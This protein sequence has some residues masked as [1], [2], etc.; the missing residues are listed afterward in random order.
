M[1]RDISVLSSH[2]FDVLIIGAGIYGATAAWDAA[3]RGLSVALIDQ[4]DFGGA[5]SANS[6]K[7]VHGGLRYLQQ[8]DIVRM[9]ESIRERR[10]LSYLAPH[11]VHPLPC[12]MPTYGHFIKGPEVMHI[13]MLLNDIIG[14]DRNRLDDPQKHIPTGKVLS[15]NNCIRLVPGVQSDRING[16]AYW[17]D[18]QIYNTD[19]LVLAFVKSAVQ[20][21]A[22][23]MNY[24]K[25]EKLIRHKG[26]IHGAAV[27]DLIHQKDFEIRSKVTL[28][29]TG[30]WT[31]SLL[32][33]LG[34]TSSRIRL[35]TAMNVIVKRSLLPECAAG[36]RGHFEYPTKSGRS[37]SGYRVLFMTP[38][39]DFTVIGT[40]HRPYDGNP[41]DMKVTEKDIDL[42]LREIQS[43]YPGDPVKREDIALALKGFLPMNGLNPKTGDVMLT[44]QYRI[45]DHSE[46]D[47]LEGILSV[48]GVKYTTARDVSEKAIDRIITKL[49]NERIKNR[50]RNL[51]LTGGDIERFK[52]MLATA[53][54]NT[55]EALTPRIMSHL[56]MNY[57]TE[58]RT[59]IKAVHADSSMAELI[60]GS[61]E[62]IKAEIVHAVCE[63]MAFTLADAVLRRTDLGS[64]GY[65]GKKAVSRVADIM[66]ELLNWNPRK[67]NE[68]IHQLENHYRRMGGFS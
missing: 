27:K 3:T 64:A 12:I 51:R 55:L 9:R 68:E 39:R 56:V 53:Q 2:E 41:D 18:A 26:R 65:P 52:E 23:A 15:R 49:R 32:N 61:P 46:E 10:I 30:A 1:Q 13:A 44:K 40:Y 22:A 24:V 47:H 8:M 34:S 58:Y 37:Y 11:F 57:G 45:Y 60:P 43:A 29:M 36:V 7:I 62:V 14:F 54:V 42:F 5:T 48:V 25:A 17:T 20:S 66:A 50:T 59:L 16:G 35:S 31:D 67:K 38:W 19:R 4:G 33:T 28:N 63:E 6:L 21:G